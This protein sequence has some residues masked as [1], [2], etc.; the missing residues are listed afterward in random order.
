VQV[1]DW[2]ASK[3]ALVDDL[4]SQAN[5]FNWVQ[6]GCL[7]W[8]KQKLLLLR[9]YVLCDNVTLQSPLRLLAKLPGKEP[10]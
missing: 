5:F 4:Q 6:F 9:Q 7:I 8:K 10:N 3:Q 2:C 1:R